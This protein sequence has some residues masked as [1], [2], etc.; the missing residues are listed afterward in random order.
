MPKAK[1]TCPVCNKK[2]MKEGGCYKH[3]PDAAK[4]KKGAELEP[5]VSKEAKPKKSKKEDDDLEEITIDFN[6]ITIEGVSEEDAKRIKEDPE[7]KA[8][9]IK[10]F[11]EQQCNP[12]D[13]SSGSDVEG[14]D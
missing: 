7:A 8:Q 14:E 4:K 12:D 13:Y 5:N 2:C 6:D 1:Y 9:I 3:H 11:K 10:W